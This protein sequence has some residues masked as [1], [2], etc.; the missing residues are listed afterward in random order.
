MFQF[1]VQI[2]QG[3][4]GYVAY[5]KLYMKYKKI[6]YINAQQMQ[7]EKNVVDKLNDSSTK[8]GKT[9]SSKKTS[10]SK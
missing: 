4:I 3:L 7:E 6:N 5:Y 2:T 8:S 1:Y 10:G 9:L